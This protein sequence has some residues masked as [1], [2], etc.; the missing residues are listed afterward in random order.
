VLGERWN[1]DD[2]CVGFPSQGAN[3]TWHVAPDFLTVP[4]LHGLLDE[5]VRK[6]SKDNRDYARAIIEELEGQRTGQVAPG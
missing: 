6:P 4:L 5:L 1:G 3:P 2:H